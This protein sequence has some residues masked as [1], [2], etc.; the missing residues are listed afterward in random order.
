MVERDYAGAEKILT[1]SSLE[2]FLPAWSPP[3]VI[4]SG[5]H[6][7]RSRRHRIGPALFCRGEA[8]YR[9]VDARLP[10]RCTASCPS[11]I[12]LCLHAEERGCHS[13]KSSSP[14]T[15]AR[16]PERISWRQSCGQPGAGL[17]TR[18]RAGPGDHANRASPVNSRRRSC[19]R[20]FRVASR[21]P[22]SVCGGSGTRF[23]ATP[24]SKKFSQERSRRQ[25]ISRDC[26]FGEICSPNSGHPIFTNWSSLRASSD[27]TT[28]P[29]YV[30]TRSSGETESAADW[31]NI[32]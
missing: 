5:P 11:R 4:L 8:G 18:G 22:N 26:E 2:D 27:G 17:C 7:P 20:I 23:A 32:G 1:D 6:Q 9:K 15:R 28:A 25:S 30:S 24:V 29:C 31:R 10:R 19:G 12:T 3:K 16:K 13:R 14:R 21:S